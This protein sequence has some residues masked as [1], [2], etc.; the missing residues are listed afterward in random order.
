MGVF[1]DILKSVKKGAEVVASRTRVAADRGRIWL[2]V[3]SLRNERKDLL[4]KL[5]E[6]VVAMREAG[7]PLDESLEPILSEIDR[8]GSEIAA[9]EEEARRVGA[10]EEAAAAAESE[11]ASAVSKSTEP[12]QD[13][14][15]GPGPS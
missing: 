9:K 3:N 13:Q 14:G 2:D 12:P 7:N 6:Q 10:E 5:G 1:D 15:A 4:T 8:L 11:A